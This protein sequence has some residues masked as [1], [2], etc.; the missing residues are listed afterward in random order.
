MRRTAVLVSGVIVLLAVAAPAWALITAPT[1][2]GGVLNESQ[3]IFT[4]TV[5]SVEPDRPG[6][7]LAVDDV[8][9]GKPPFKKLAVNL[10]GDADAIKKKETP[11]LLKRVAPKLPIFVF[12]NQNDRNFTAFAYSNGTWFQMAGERAEDGDVLR[13]PFT[14]IEPYLR[15]TFKGTTAEMKNAVADGLSG[16]AEPPPPNLKEKPGVGPEVAP[17]DKPKNKDKKEAS[18]LAIDAARGPVFAVI[19]MFVVGPLALLAMLFPAVFGGLTLVL[20]RWTTALTVLSLNSTL[21]FLQNLFG[22]YLIT[23]WWGTPTALWLMMSL[24]TLAGALWAWR[25]HA[26]SLA[27]SAAPPSDHSPVAYAPGSPS[28]EFPWSRPMARTVSFF[29]PPAP[30]RFEPP[31]R[32]E[33][34][35]LGALSLACLATAFFLPRSLSEYGLL[36]KTVVMCNVGVWAA[37]LHACYLRWVVARRRDARP[38]L[39]GEGV[40]LGAMLLIC[41]AFAFTMAPEAQAGDGPA[42]QVRSTDDKTSKGAGEFAVRLVKTRGLFKPTAPSWIASSPRVDGDRVYVGAV[43]GAAFRSGAVYCLDRATGAVR[44][45]FNDGGRMKDVFSSPCVA[46]GKVYIGEGFHQHSDCKLYCLDADSGKKLWQVQ[47]GSH[48]ESSPCVV[49]GK[50]YFG[51][52]DDGLFCVVAATGAPVWHEGKGLHVDASPLVV[53]GRVYCGSGVGDAY[54]ETCVFCLDAA[55]GKEIWRKPTDLPVWGESTLAGGRLYV[56]AG[57]GNFVDSEGEG[58]LAESKAK[59]AGA[60]LC[61]NA[62]NGDRIWR[63]DV[64]D[65]VHVHPAVDRGCV[66]FASRD[67]HC[68]CLDRADGR[69]LWK[70]D[71]G[72]PVVASPALVGCPECG[73]SVSL[74]VA[75]GDGQLYCLDPQT[76]AR[77]WVLD[78]AKEQKQP[79]ELFSTPS[80]V[81]SREADGD[82]RRV[83]IGSGFNY[84]QRGVLYCIE[85]VRGRK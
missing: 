12:L 10:T 3:Y 47:T 79:A 5:E 14:H 83:Y 8:L 71:L 41:I 70:K 35:V 63:Y 65:G 62:A 82:H 84:F 37:T 27:A 20:K 73:C 42:A 81:V 49:D 1:P 69:M 48:T 56:G 38:G 54:Q 29:P 11:E 64:A 31:G 53:G 34:I 80:V 24:V 22:A 68:Y 36:E 23:S 75:A 72:S 61:Y 16:K 13:L 66:Y 40:L 85:D 17:P 39:P 46:D 15:R 67:H 28:T 2:L 55:T 44:W 19:P 18:T 26:L 43:H 7:V 33:L 32:G 50:A 59:P 25:K 45:A 51:A 30:V 9:K 52:G 77:E 76:G 21:L 6:M 58:A 4:A 60:L 78:V 74:Y 57:N